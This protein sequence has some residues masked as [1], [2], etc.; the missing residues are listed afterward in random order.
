M[1]IAS[2]D[3]AKDGPEK[4]QEMTEWAPELPELQRKFVDVIASEM[5]D[6]QIDPVHVRELLGVLVRRE[7]CAETKAEIAARRLDRI[8]REQNEADEAEREARGPCESVEDR[9]GGRRQVVRRQGLRLRES[10]NRLAPCREMK[11]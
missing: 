3:E 11:C 1:N 2:S 10:P 8:E 4:E 5:T 9:K 6:V 7:R